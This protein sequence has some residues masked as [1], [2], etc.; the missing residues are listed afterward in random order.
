MGWIWIW[1]WTNYPALLEIEDTNAKKRTNLSTN[2]QLIASKT[3]S[4]ILSPSC[5]PHRGK[6]Q[7]YTNLFATS[8]PKSLIYYPFPF[9]YSAPSFLHRRVLGCVHI[10]L[11]ALCTCVICLHTL[12]NLSFLTTFLFFYALL[13]LGFLNKN[14][15]KCVLLFFSKW[16]D[17]NIIIIFCYLWWTCSIRYIAEHYQGKSSADVSG[18]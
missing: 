12:C 11:L 6:K 7:T 15:C 17:V 1:S 8:L 10:C 16:C 13:G 9:A 14:F 3:L 2:G 4:L 5:T 18:S